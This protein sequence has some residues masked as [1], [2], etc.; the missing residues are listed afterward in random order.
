MTDTGIKVD[1]PS[2]LIEA[3]RARSLNLFIGA[4]FSKNVSHDIPSANQ[5]ILIAARYAGIDDRLLSIHANDD[6]MLVAEY[7]EIEGALQQAIAE[8]ERVLH[9]KAYLVTA[10]RPHIQLTQMECSTIF[11]TNWDWW[12]EKAFEYAQ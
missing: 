12:I 2:A 8:L 3:A 11:T 1:I 5:V 7:L 10:S 6:Y 9:D 4:G